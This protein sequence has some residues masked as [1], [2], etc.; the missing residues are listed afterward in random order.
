M[1]EV[2]FARRAAFVALFFLAALPATP[3]FAQTVVFDNGN[4]DSGGT[5]FSDPGA[6]Q[7]LAEDFTFNATTT[8]DTVRWFGAYAFA[9]TPTAPDA[10]TIS[11]F[12]TTAG[13]PNATPRTDE[14]FAVGNSA[15][16]VNLGPTSSGFD[17]Y[18]YEATLTAPITVV[19]GA[20]GMEI[21]NDTT[22]DTDDV[23]G[24]AISKKPG[25]SFV[26]NAPNGEFN[27]NGGG[28][29]FQLIDSTPVVVP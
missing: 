5:L 27:V 19:A 25:I 14:V 9:D 18:Q 3:T 23:W 2:T 21:V 10:F 1:M 8:F 29:A 11:F 22:A 24:W 6:S 4:V 12:D 13:I 17:I 26:R 16:R 20:Y 7:L 15:I 28:V